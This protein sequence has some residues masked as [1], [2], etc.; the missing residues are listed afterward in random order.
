MPISFGI[1]RRALAP[2]IR[3]VLERCAPVRMC[4]VKILKMKQRGQLV[5]CG[6]DFKLPSGDFGVTLEA[7]STG[8]YEPETTRVLQTILEDGMTFVDIG[9]HVGL[10]TLPAATWVGEAGKVLAFEPH[11]ENFAILQFNTRS[12]G[13]EQRIDLVQSAVADVT[14]KM[15]LHLST[16]NTGDHQLFHQGRRETV[17][18]A[19]TTL[20]DYFKAGAQVDVIKIDVQ[21]AEF[22]AFSGMSRVVKEN[23]NLKLIWEL[24]PQQLEDAGTSA[25]EVLSWLDDRGF[26]HVIIDEVNRECKEITSR[27]ILQTCPKDSFINILS[28]QHV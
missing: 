5:R 25:S 10:F 8:D 19:C 28:V 20:D 26:S 23:P 17:E 22:A 7:E 14:K 9:A 3:P 21:G 27:E 1:I 12:N 15:Q 24:S 2:M 4:A 16:F 6:L 11:P 13:L 18:V